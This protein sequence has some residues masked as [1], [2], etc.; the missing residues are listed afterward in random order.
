[1][2]IVHLA[3]HCDEV[4]NGVVN[5]AVD[6]AVKQREAGHTVG[7]V[8]SGGSMVPMLAS[9]EVEH[10]TAAMTLRR[11]SAMVAGFTALSK[12]LSAF[13]PDIVHAHM[14]PG[15]VFARL[16]R[17]K[18]RFRLVTTVH[19]APQPQAVLMGL[20]DRVIV[21]SAAN[22]KSMA[23]RGLP[24]RK[25]RVVKNGPL[26]SPRRAALSGAPDRIELQRPAIVTVARLF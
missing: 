19:N 23:N 26:D 21:V 9:H 16:L 12:A 1:M 11:P 8:S 24:Q 2:R 17:R 22:L 4:G 25:L 15:A 18:A 3:P 7:I 10:F 14:V 20:A 6:L 5:V 13:R